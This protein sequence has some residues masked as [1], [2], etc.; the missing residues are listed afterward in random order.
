MLRINAQ[1]VGTQDSLTP[2]TRVAAVVGQALRR[3]AETGGD[4]SIALGLVERRFSAATPTIF[5]NESCPTIP[6]TACTQVNNLFLEPDFIQRPGVFGSNRFKFVVG[7]ELG[8]FFQ[9]SSQGK[10]HA[11]YSGD[12]VNPLCACRHVPPSMA[13]T[14]CSRSKR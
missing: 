13:C 1:Q 8:H 5:A 4:L 14:A 12:D 7:H 10:L 9:Q 6:N 2:T 11:D 3:E